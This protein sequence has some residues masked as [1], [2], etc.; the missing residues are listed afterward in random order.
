MA[1]NSDVSNRISELDSIVSGLKIKV[2]VLITFTDSHHA[3]IEASALDNAVELALLTKM[4]RL[5][6]DMKDKIFDGYGPLSTF[7]GK[8]DIAYAL[9]IIPKEFLSP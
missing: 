8:I 5:S 9:E 4:R 3:L 6:R 7:A 2:D 1:S